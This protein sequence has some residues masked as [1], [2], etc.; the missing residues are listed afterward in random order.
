MCV[1]ICDFLFSND[2]VEEFLMQHSLSLLFSSK[3]RAAVCGVNGLAD[4]K[5]CQ[6][7]M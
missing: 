5:E 6:L 7:E 1:Y 4:I 2:S 3:S